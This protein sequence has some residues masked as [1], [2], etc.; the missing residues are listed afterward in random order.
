MNYLIALASLALFACGFRVARIL[1]IS[2][3]AMRR[4]KN[5]FAL[6]AD[7]NAT[8]EE[9]ERAARAASAALFGRF[10]MIAAL[11][12]AALAAPA[13][14]VLIAVQSG[15]ADS[16]SIYSALLSPWLIAAAIALFAVE[17][18]FRR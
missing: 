12:L 1:A 16:D 15:A 8:E 13:L 2:S 14:V 3:D 4:A 5:A 17:F 18:W 7:R 6:M 11:T 10:L 9:K